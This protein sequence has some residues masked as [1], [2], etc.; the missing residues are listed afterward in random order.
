MKASA[1]VLLQM[2]TAA[3]GQTSAQFKLYSK[4][5]K[6]P[7]AGTGAHL[8]GSIKKKKNQ[9]KIT[10]LYSHPNLAGTL[11]ADVTIIFW[12]FRKLITDDVG[13]NSIWRG[14]VFTQLQPCCL[15][16]PHYGCKKQREQTE[17]SVLILSM[18][19]DTGAQQYGPCSLLNFLFFL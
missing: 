2:G 10:P 6:A 9:S 3:W 14:P 5:W 7:P 17:A 18:Q 12:Q 8:R 15:P 16:E 13:V 1:E 4:N 11:P 19:S